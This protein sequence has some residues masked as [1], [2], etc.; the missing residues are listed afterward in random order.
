MLQNKAKGYFFNCK[1]LAVL[2]LVITG[3]V[4]TIGIIRGLFGVGLETSSSGLR[5]LLGVVIE[6]LVIGDIAGL[7]LSDITVVGLD[8][9]FATC[10]T[11]AMLEDFL[12]L[13]SLDLKK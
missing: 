9:G 4:L 1:T 11:P 13:A 6:V 7:G 12:T 3:L 8:A 2:D 5:F 10:G